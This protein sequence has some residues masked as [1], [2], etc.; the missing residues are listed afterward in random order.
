MSVGFFTVSSTSTAATRKREVKTK[1][2][3]RARPFF[4]FSFLFVG[5][6]F[7]GAS[8]GVLFW[9]DAGVVSVAVAVYEFPK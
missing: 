7:D 4:F 2:E 6:A 5:V 8:A 3:R 1:E 9:S